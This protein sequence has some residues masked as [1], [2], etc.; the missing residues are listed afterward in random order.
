MSEAATIEPNAGLRAIVP[1]GIAGIGGYAA[2][3]SAG[4]LRPRVVF[5]LAVHAVL[6]AVMIAV[7]RVARRAGRRA[8]TAIFVAAVIFRLVMAAAPPTLSDDVF[9]YVWDGRVQAAGHHPYKLAPADPERR[10]FRDETVYPRINH[11]EI[12][13]IYPP[14]A[15]MAFAALSFLRAGVSGFK[16]AMGALDVG[17]VMAL[18]VL[19]RALGRPR[20]RVVLYAWNPLAVVETAGSGHV[21]P[22]GIVLLL[23]AIVW[24]VRGKV[25]RAAVAL[26]GAIQA[27][28]LPLLLVPGFARRMRAAA[29]LALAAT[30]LLINAPYALRGPAYGAGVLAYAYRWE[31]GSIA[32]P[33]F[34]RAYDWLDAAPQLKSGIAWMQARWGTADT[35]LWDLLYRLVWPEELARLTVGALALAWAVAQSFRPRI[36]PAHEA[37]LA[38][39][40]AL[41]LAPTLHP[42]YVLWVLPLASASLAGGWLLLAALV[43]LQY[44]AGAGEVPWGLRCAIL[45]PPVAWMVRDS[46]VARRNAS[47]AK[48]AI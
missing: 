31:H 37:R 20:D 3:A 1:A 28:L 38:L 35:R 4:D 44:L 32:F 33:A 9:R 21:E 11:P 47:E 42:W 22:L 14:L 19:L 23:L 39:G 45:L 41:L 18:A 25:T 13:T 46:W 27:K 30:V 10:E 7:W 6:L 12:V 48:D 26:G 29:L 36:D 40:G 8:W 2:L 16:L 34:L 43:P 15:E 5:Y 17:V 24:I